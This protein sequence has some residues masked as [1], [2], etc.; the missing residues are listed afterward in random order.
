M[1]SRGSGAKGTEPELRVLSR[2]CLARALG[3]ATCSRSLNTS[4]SQSR[5]RRGL[6]FAP[7]A[8]S[9]LSGGADPLPLPLTSSLRHLVPG[10]D[11]S[12]SA[13]R[14]S[15]AAPGGEPTRSGPCPQA[16]ATPYMS[17]RWR[18]RPGAE[19]QPDSP[20]PGWSVP[21]TQSRGRILSETGPQGQGVD[22]GR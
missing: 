13:Q 20:P 14:P 12:P 5:T 22:A 7:R 8:P 17:T 11:G 15:P 1:R 9:V 6:W 3:S 19:R 21:W 16:V 10:A 4:L 18:S 2:H